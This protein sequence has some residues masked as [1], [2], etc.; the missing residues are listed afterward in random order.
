MQV[1]LS[2]VSLQSGIY[3]HNLFNF[4]VKFPVLSDVLVE[5][6]SSVTVWE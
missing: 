4:N 2:A 3:C 6:N 1:W 5:L